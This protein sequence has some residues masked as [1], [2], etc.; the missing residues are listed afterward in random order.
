MNPSSGKKSS[1]FRQIFIFRQGLRSGW[2]LA[3]FFTFY[4]A[5]TL[6]TQAGFAFVPRLR[7]WAAAQPYGIITPLNQI[8]FTSLE[9]IILVFSVWIVSLAER[10]SIR[11][12]GIAGGT[13]GGTRFAL[14]LL[15]GFTMASSLVGLI[16]LFG[17]YSLHGLAIGRDECAQ[18]ALLY[19]L[20]FLCV[21]FFRSL[22]RIFA[23]NAATW[24]RFLAGS[25][26][27][28]TG[29][30]RSPFAEFGWSLERRSACRLFRFDG[31]VFIET[32]R[33]P[34]LYHRRPRGF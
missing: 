5:L 8:E 25:R 3:I 29:L 1:L 22:S 15:F 10:G 17:G 20:G 12:Y 4:S 26:D 31:S 16:D 6:G 33:C 34:V 24:N 23:S 11:H 30:W 9:L 28:V 32:Y 7:A 21:A 27:F 14:G 19:G 2:S 13:S 18:N